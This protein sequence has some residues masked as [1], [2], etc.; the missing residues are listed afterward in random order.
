M[1]NY[2]IWQIKKFGDI[3]PVADF[4]ILPPLTEDEV[5]DLVETKFEDE[6]TTAI[7]NEY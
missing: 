1:N 4:F 6:H 7:A 3:T 2:E 5:K